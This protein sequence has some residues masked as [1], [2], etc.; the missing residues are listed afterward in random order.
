MDNNQLSPQDNQIIFQTIKSIL[1]DVSKY[2]KRIYI[3]GIVIVSLFA[4]KLLTYKLIY[5]IYRP[6]YQSNRRLYDFIEDFY[7]DNHTI[8]FIIIVQLTVLVFRYQKSL[9]KALNSN[10]EHDLVDSF[11]I[12]KILFR[13]IAFFLILGFFMYLFYFAIGF[14]NLTYH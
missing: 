4:V 9:A 1:I 12:L 11:R 5:P 3:T 14:Y 13:M 10:N 2:L 8:Y 7:M 6:L